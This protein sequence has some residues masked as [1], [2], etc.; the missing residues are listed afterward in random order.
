M[1][2]GSI[3]PAWPACSHSK[4]PM[5]RSDI[6]WK[7]WTC[8]DSSLFL[9]LVVPVVLLLE[10]SAVSENIFRR[11]SSE[12]AL[13]EEGSCWLRTVVVL[14]MPQWKESAL[15]WLSFAKRLPRLWGR[16]ADTFCVCTPRQLLFI[17]RSIWSCLFGQIGLKIIWHWGWTRR[18]PRA[19]QAR[20]D[21]L[22]LALSSA[23]NDNFQS[24]F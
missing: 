6:L 14:L 17:S 16:P 4:W 2:E 21:S 3:L 8:A 11:K 23:G 13:W 19:V 7:P 1:T 18:F 12:C 20:S 9:P 24:I 22:G 5:L 10:S 15:G